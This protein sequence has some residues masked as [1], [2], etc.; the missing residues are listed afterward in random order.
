MLGKYNKSWNINTKYEIIVYS[1]T[2]MFEIK[3]KQK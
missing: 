2:T 1:D 3:T